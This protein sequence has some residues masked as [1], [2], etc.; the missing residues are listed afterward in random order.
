MHLHVEGE[1][2]T[3]QVGEHVRL[4]QDVPEPAGVLGADL[5]LVG[6]GEAID[7]VDGMVAQNELVPGIGMLVQHALEPLGLDVP[8]PAQ[9]G[10]EGMDEDQQEV[11]PM[12]PVG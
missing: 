8:L 3:A 11:A 4:H 1:D 12:D 6:S 2:M 9:S 7:G 10:P 5:A